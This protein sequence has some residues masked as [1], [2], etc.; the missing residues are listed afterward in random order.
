MSLYITL[1]HK[2]TERFR[3]GNTIALSNAELTNGLVSKAKKRRLETLLLCMLEVA[4]FQR[5]HLQRQC[6]YVTKLFVFVF[7]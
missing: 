1:L 2:C 5:R 3:G 6:A 7:V 4:W